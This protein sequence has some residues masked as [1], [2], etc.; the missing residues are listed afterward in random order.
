ME[1]ESVKRHVTTDH[2]IRSVGIA[3][4]ACGVVADAG[5]GLML[6][7]GASVWLLLLHPLAVALWLCGTQGGSRLSS[8]LP[9][10]S[11]K[12]AGKPAPT[13]HLMGALLSGKTIVLTLVA[14]ALF[15][16]FG[17]IGWSIAAAL[18]ALPSER[19]MARAPS[20]PTDHETD[21][22]ALP[23]GPDDLWNAVA[24]QPL[25]DVLREPDPSLRRA[26]IRIL[27]NEPSREAVRMLRS[28][29][30]DPDPDVRSE[31]SATL[32]R[33]ENLLN[34]RLSDALARVQETPQYADPYAELAAGYSDYAACDLLDPASARLY[35][36]R[37]CDALEGATALAP[38]RAD[39]WLALARAQRGRGDLP[40]AMAAL[41]QVTALAP[42]NADAA[43]L[44]ME[45][46]FQARR[47]DTLTT[48]PHEE[49]SPAGELADMRELFGWWARDA[50]DDA[51]LALAASGSVFGE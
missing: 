26:A 8:L 41:D 13:D 33:F 46:A 23:A 32:F 5:I 18:A 14:L 9:G 15:P 28:L 7:R 12:Q 11:E 30:V 44:R 34:K 35:L 19:H 40:A 24:V 3:V 27:S 2:T 31:A 47:W 17:L 38:E 25:V 45:L 49:R 10:L 4:T 48:I 39:L 20:I 21:H 50:A 36:S 29:L 1:M 43:L 16:G 22:P 6:L 37:A 42:D 51:A